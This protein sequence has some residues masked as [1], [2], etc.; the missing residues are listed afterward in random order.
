MTTAKSVTATFLAQTVPVITTQPS[1]RTI[2]IGQSATFTV[3][4]TGTPTPTYKWQLSTNGGLT[5]ANLNNTGPYTGT[6][7]ATLTVT[8]APLT[9]NQSRF[10]CIATNTK[11]SATS[12]AAVLTVRSDTVTAA[13][14]DFD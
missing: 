2:S 12:S 3:V 13:A 8:N 14:A 10:R 4:A 1:S 7:T 5:W 6:T 11:G 9:L